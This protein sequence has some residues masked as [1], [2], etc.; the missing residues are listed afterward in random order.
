MKVK[1]I[2]EI[3]QDHPILQE[4]TLNHLIAQLTHENYLTDVKAVI[5]SYNEDYPKESGI[6]LHDYSDDFFNQLDKII[7][8]KHFR[9]IQL[10]EP[11]TLEYALKHR[12]IYV[13]SINRHM[14]N[15]YT[16]QDFEFP[17]K[18][19]DPLLDA[20]VPALCFETDGREY[21]LSTKAHLMYNPALS[22]YKI[23][24]LLTSQYV[25]LHLGFF[26]EVSPK[27]F[28]LNSDKKF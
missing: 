15:S 14:V 20:P 18:Y 6:Y 16:E 7:G 21:I 13:Q 3:S 28:E 23:Q 17:Q 25:L 5:D 24:D 4:L 8:A 2:L 27:W 10:T 22:T 26:H 19:N 11:L 12:G 9:V 1:K